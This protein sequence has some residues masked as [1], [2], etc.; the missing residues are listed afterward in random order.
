MWLKGSFQSWSKLETL[1][2]L[3]QRIGAWFLLP[4]KE[5]EER[6]QAQKSPWACTKKRSTAFWWQ[7]EI[8]LLPYFPQTPWWVFQS[9]NPQML[10]K[11]KKIPLGLHA[12]NEMQETQ[13]Q[14]TALDWQCHHFIA[15]VVITLRGGDHFPMSRNTAGWLHCL[16]MQ[17]DDFPPCHSELHFVDKN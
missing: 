1:A 17:E 3:F 8:A 6:N 16:E 9:L 12:G 11:K 4:A 14:N 10:K 7:Q 2:Q 13:Y 5:R 15:R